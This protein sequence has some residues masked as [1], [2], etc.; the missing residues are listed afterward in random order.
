MKDA[1]T[2]QEI[3][4]DTSSKKVRDHYA[5]WWQESSRKSKDIFN[6][7][8]VDATTIST[9]QDFVPALLN[10]FKQRGH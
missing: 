7:S 2:S 3:W 4:V 1:E 6:K 5:A 8:R 9:D 10:L